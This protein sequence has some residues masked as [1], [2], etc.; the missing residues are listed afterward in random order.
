MKKKVN[1]IIDILIKVLDKLATEKNLVLGDS[2]STVFKS[3]W[4]KIRYPLKQFDVCNIL[5]ATA[6]G[7]ENPNSKTQAYR[8][9][10]DKLNSGIDYDR[11][12]ILLGEIDTGF[13]IWYRSQKY[14]IPVEETYKKTLKVYTN[15][16]NNVAKHNKVIVISA[17]L[18]T[19]S[20]NNDWGEVANLR[21]EIK[22]SQLKR[23]NLTLKFNKEVEKYCL[24]NGIDY[25]NLDAQSLGQDGLVKKTLINKNK[26]DHH[27]DIRK[28]LKIIFKNLK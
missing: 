9:F 25:L 24:S 14:G 18:P 2:H 23:T 22:V 12:I 6:S 4:F 16:V 3:R 21:K 17:P 1:Y 11:V 26:L 8:A 5:G 19:I 13:I 7:L 10:S 27:Y 15:F 20:D 28:Y